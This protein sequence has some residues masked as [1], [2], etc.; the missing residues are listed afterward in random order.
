MLDYPCGKFGDC[1][2]SCFGFIVRTNKQTKS[3]IHTD[4]RDCGRRKYVNSC[5]NRSNPT[6]RRTIAMDLKTYTRSNTLQNT[7]C[8][9]Y[10]VTIAQQIY[11]VHTT[12]KKL[13]RAA[14][15]HCLSESQYNRDVKSFMNGL[16]SCFHTARQPQVIP[17]ISK[18]SQS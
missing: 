8:N 5:M 9:K 12:E 1:S 13:Q 16:I 2:F 11:T 15:G 4:S 6:Q 17:H 3:Q 18:T 7:S 10:A 14:R